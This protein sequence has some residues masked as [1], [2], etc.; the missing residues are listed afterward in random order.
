MVGEN[1]KKYPEVIQQIIAEGHHIGNHTYN[2]VEGWRTSKYNYYKNTLKCHTHAPSTLFRPP[3]GRISRGQHK[4]LAKRYKIIMWSVLSGDYNK[5]YSPQKIISS[6]AQNTTPGAIVVFHDS[7]KA[8][9]NLQLTLPVILKQYQKNGYQMVAI[10]KNIQT[11]P[12]QRGA[13]V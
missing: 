6:V 2:H 4:S 8:K 5:A 11:H 9:Q 10:P 12:T 13:G 1:A 3:Y 7:E